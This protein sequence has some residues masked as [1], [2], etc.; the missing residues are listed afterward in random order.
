[1]ASQASSSGFTPAT[2]P[3]ISGFKSGYRNRE[4]KTV[5]P[6]GVM[7]E[8]SQ[9]VLTNTFNRVAIRQG[10]TLDGQSGASTLAPILG[11]FDWQRHTG[12]TRHLRSGF[13]TAAENGKLQYRFVATVG[14]NWMG[15]VFTEGQVYWIDLVT[16]LDSVLI[17]FA[18]FWDFNT[19][20]KDLLLFVNGSSK[21]WEWSGGVTTLASA[22]NAA[23][24]IGI[25]SQ[26]GAVTAVT[27]AS[28]GGGYTVGDILTINNGGKNALLRVT[29]TIPSGQVNAVTIV[30][31]GGGYETA[32]N[33][34]VLGGTGSGATFN[35]TS[36]SSNAGTNYVVGDILTVTGGNNDAQFEV[37]RIGS[38]SGNPGKIVQLKLLN[39]GTGY[40]A[41]T[42]PLAGGSGINATLT[43]GTVVQGYIQKTGI[44][45]WA[46]EGF[47]NV[48]SPRSVVINGN[49]YTYTGGE[50]TTFLTG[51]SPDP[52]G[53]PVQSVI[54]Q[55][56]VVTNNYDMQGLPF[57]LKNT[58]I[59]NLKNQIYIAG[60]RN[61]SIYVS[62]T[63]N[64]KDYTFSTPVRSPGEGAILTLDG[65]PTALVPQQ[66]QMYVSAGQ[67]QWY[68]TRFTLS[69]DLA[70]ESLN[71]E[72][73]KTTSLQASQT[74]ELLTK[75]KNNLC[76]TSFEP[77]VNMLGTA[78][79]YLNDPQTRDLSFS[80]VNDMNGYDF[81]DGSIIYHKQFVY[82]AVPKSN[83]MLIYNMTD[84]EHPYWE[85]PQVLP[86]SRFSVIDGVLYG[87]S[88][89]VS[90][91]YKLFDGTNDLGNP[92]EAK[93]TFSFVNYG[94][95]AY[96]K[97]MTEYYVEGYISQNMSG[98]SALFLQIQ[99]DVDGCATNVS[100]PIDGTDKRIVCLNPPNN[101]LGKNSLGK[102]P[103]GGNLK[104][105]PST[106]TPPKFR[107]IKTMSSPSFYEEQTTFYSYGNDVRWEILAF[108]SNSF[109]AAEGNVSIKQ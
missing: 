59:A 38:F 104:V 65:V 71:I 54:H 88:Y 91:S 52:S 6:P 48:E 99:Y 90:E 49:I 37:V 97:R 94:D 26:P 24:V 31:G 86:I 100:Y 61:Q 56:P 84:P 9:N 68:F 87:H 7:V 4:D 2:Y 33:Q 81:T 106:A 46:E 75:I 41:A 15:N 1:M 93:A 21:I 64:Y 3:L 80:I 35:I 5:L 20:L 101:S 108:A 44:T 105:Q 19:E 34:P 47:Y 107:V 32:L 53:E 58:L 22:S 62:Q 45:S 66:E 69:G 92:I 50:T 8:G 12:D 42:D 103:L 63:N 17:R 11:S 30:S 60:E 25:W 89:Y 28:A 43:I 83:R 57:D 39:P 67:D 102:F 85:A 27:I 96:P 10:Y 40:S 16:G 77:I 55:N 79:D 73:L 98:S 36:I 14:D 23:G 78:Q 109:M 29:A 13:L 18:D 82:L 95:R 76:F 72:R 74:Q 51:I 70:S